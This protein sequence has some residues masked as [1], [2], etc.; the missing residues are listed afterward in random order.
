MIRGG[1][2]GAN[3]LTG[4]RFE[5]R[6]D[7]LAVFSKLPGYT[8][9]GNVIS[10]NGT[11]VAKSYKKHSLYRYLK[12]KGINYKEIISKQ[13]LPDEA[14]IVEINKTLFVI[15]MKFQETSGSV[16]EKL[17]TCAFKKQQYE[18]LF[19]PL[20][21]KVEYIY[22]LNEWFEHPSYRDVLNYVHAVG[23]HA[24][25]KELPLQALG[26]PVPTLS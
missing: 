4:L 13:L 24:Y 18:K 10:Y 23:C 17:Q 26:L 11:E 6:Q 7:L 14:L 2:G 3:T 16:D 25:F 21:Y 22:L 12:G 1:K 9:D 19:A 5:E 20:G 15:E 8:I